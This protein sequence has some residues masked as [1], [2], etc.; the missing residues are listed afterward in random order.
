MSWNRRFREHRVIL[1]L[2]LEELN[3]IENSIIS[4]VKFEQER[5][6]STYEKQIETLRRHG[7]QMNG[8]FFSNDQT[9]NNSP[10]SPD[11][12]ER[13]GER[14]PLVIDGE[15]DVNIMCEDYYT[16][17]ARCNAGYERSRL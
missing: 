10:I 16:R 7:D 12:P 9:Q 5:V 3:L 15:E 14:L 1:A 11:T 4:F 2:I 6:T 17:S 13:L 8:Q